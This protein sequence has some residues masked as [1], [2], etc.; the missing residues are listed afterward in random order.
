MILSIALMGICPV[1]A[2]AETIVVTT[3]ISDCD[4]M[5]RT[6]ILRH[7]GRSNRREGI[8]FSTRGPQAA[9]DA[10]CYSNSRYRVVEQVVRW[11][12][13]R[14]GWFAVRRYEN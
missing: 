6:G 13:I 11:S 1:F 2:Q 9:L 14:R 10:C 7:S 8:G 12:P 3:A 4:E 5:A